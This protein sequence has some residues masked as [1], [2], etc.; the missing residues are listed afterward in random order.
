MIH[1]KTHALNQRK[2]IAKII[3]TSTALG[4]LLLSGCKKGPEYDAEGFFEGTEVIVSAE[5]TGKLL[6]F[7]VKEGDT[8]TAGQQVGVIDTVQLSLKERQLAQ[9]KAAVSSESPN[10]QAQISAIQA[11]LNQA[12]TEQ[13][14]VSNLLKDGA[15]TQ[16]QMDNANSAVKAIQGELDAAMS[17]LQKTKSSIS[18]N[19]KAVGFGSAQV[20]DMI[21]KCHVTSP[22]SGTVLAKYAEAGEMAVA[23][24]PLFKVCDL[25]SM[26]LRAY[27]TSAQLADIKLGQKADVYADYGG[28]KVVKYPGKVTWIASDSEFTPKSVQTQDSRS[29]LVYAVK[30]AVKNDG[31]LKI[32]FYG[33]VDF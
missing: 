6:D 14:R 18:Q 32:G 26:W 33:G 29:N 5:G 20:A 31:R 1:T 24:H 4:A 19:A 11:R 30:V 2:L 12:R 8:L 23:G 17:T 13:R 28:G 10:I 22:I 21:D 25:D 7:N 16:Q 15:A 3:I 9:Q 27:V